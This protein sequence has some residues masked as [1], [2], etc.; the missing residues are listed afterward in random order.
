[1]KGGAS[2]P[3]RNWAG[4]HTYTAAALHQPQTLTELQA[5]LRAARSVR[6]I[7]TRHSFTDIGD[8]DSLIGF[9]RLADAQR[10]EIDHD[11]STVTVGPAVTFA[12]LAAELNRQ[13]WALENL[14]SLPHISVCGG[15]ATATHGSGDKVGNLATLV[16]GIRFLTAEGDVVTLGAD[17]PR[18]PG[19]AVHLG[20]LGVVLDVTLR[21]VPYYE[22]SQTAFQ[23]LEWDALL[24]NFDAV[25]ALGR[26][27]SVFHRF[28]PRTQ[29]LWV[30]SDPGRLPPPEIFGA[31]VARVPLH[32]LQDGDPSAA[33]AQLGAPGPWSERLPHF[34]SGFMPSAGSEIQSE[35]FVARGEAVAAIRELRTLGDRLAPALLVGELRSVAADELWLSPEHGRD[36]LAVHFTW[37]REPELV[38]A[39]VALIERA[40]APFAIRPH[41]GK[42]FSLEQEALARGYARSADFAKLRSEMDPRGIFVN[43]WARQHVPFLLEA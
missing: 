4:N 10:I 22:V 26:S 40:L 9:E 13:G 11:S 6:A 17:D 37:Q 2:E 33:T 27:V 1:V 14:A 8:A 43:R 42:V 28:G 7:A 16:I 20:L 21:V 12:Q 34:R 36:T 15:I 30:K 38:A 24:E 25:F 19:A 3:L 39:N 23:A 5:L 31:R 32:P 35:L 29:A 41:W 18:L